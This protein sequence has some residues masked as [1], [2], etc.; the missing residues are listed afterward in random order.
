MIKIILL[1][2]KFFLITSIGLIIGFLS[3]ELIFISD[4][5]EDNNFELTIFFLS[6]SL[7]LLLFG[8]Q[9][10]LYFNRNLINIKRFKSDFLFHRVS[11]VKSLS[12]G[13]RRV[14]SIFSIVFF[15]LQIYLISVLI[16]LVCWKEGYFIANKD[17]S[18]ETVII[19][20]LI[21]NIPFLLSSIC[22]NGWKL[23]N[24]I[25]E[26]FGKEAMSS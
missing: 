21:L 12:L 7:F 17:L 4:T 14:L 20:A 23:I 18:P 2:F 6:F 25:K 9:S 13:L 1:F 3:Y 5:F 8:A 16:F 26:G 15:T 19:I 22:T 11:A 10:I 24:W